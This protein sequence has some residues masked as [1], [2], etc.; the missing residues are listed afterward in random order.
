MTR[1]MTAGKPMQLIWQF[2]IPLVFGNLFQQMYNMVDTIIVGKYLG[3]SALTSVGS[4]ASGSVWVPA[5]A[6]ESRWR[7]FSGRRIIL[8]CANIS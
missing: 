7:S 3:L 2:S 5:A 6:W 4:T 8:P 1:D